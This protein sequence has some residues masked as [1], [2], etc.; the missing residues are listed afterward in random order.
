MAVDSDTQAVDFAGALGFAFDN[1]EKVIN[2]AGNAGVFD[3]TDIHD[4]QQQL[5]AKRAKIWE[6][7]QGLRGL[8]GAVYS[9][10]DWQPS[11]QEQMD[12][13]TSAQQYSA[14]G[15]AKSAAALNSNQMHAQ[16]QQLRSQVDS[17]A[18]NTTKSEFE[19][20]MESLGKSYHDQLQAADQIQ[21]GRTYWSQGFKSQAEAN[22]YAQHLRDAAGAI[23]DAESK[24]LWVARFGQMESDQGRL[25]VLNQLATGDTTGAARAA[26]ETE[27]D[28]QQLAIDPNDKER[29]QQFQ[30]IRE[31][32]LA[33]FDADA[34]K[35]AKFSQS[36]SDDRIAALREEAKDAQ[37]RGEGK[38]DEAKVSAL[39]FA[40]EQRARS[41]QEQADAEGDSTRKAQ[42]LREAAAATQ[43]GQTERDALQRELRRGDSNTD[44]S[45]IGSGSNL[46]DV[47]KRLENATTKLEK[48][49]S[50]LKNVSLLKD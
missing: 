3:R 39:N 21:N 27:L 19:Q 25:S 22:A 20:Q 2:E 45:G 1:V 24:K 28:T 32:S 37:L 10:L 47:S 7:H 5:E 12:E 50:N 34:A 18:A 41:L 33:N 30:E 4:P 16:L 36:Q 13:L 17:A 44:G 23:H 35:Q 38:D 46:A 6:E 26:L 9:A 8:V 15:D 42:L 11:Y 29:L 14:I 40:T 49:V 31:K 43:A 48:M